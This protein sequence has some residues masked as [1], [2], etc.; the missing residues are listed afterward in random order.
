MKPDEINKRIA[1]FCK[2]K[3]L[4]SYFG[5]VEGLWEDPNGKQQSTIPNYYGDLNAI[6]EAENHIMDENSIEYLKWLN[7]LSCPWHAS[8]PKRAEA[9]LRTIGQWEEGCPK[10]ANDIREQLNHLTK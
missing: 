1:L 3:Q 4:S 9:F 2:W 7:K 8:A 10:T 5:G 6:H